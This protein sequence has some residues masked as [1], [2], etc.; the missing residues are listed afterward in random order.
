MQALIRVS[1]MHDVHQDSCDMCVSFVQM[2]PWVLPSLQSSN[3]DHQVG[4]TSQAALRSESAAAIASFFVS[5]LTACARRPHLPWSA[6]TA[7][8]AAHSSQETQGATNGDASADTPHT[9]TVAPLCT[10][11]AHSG[12]VLLF[13]TVTAAMGRFRSQMFVNQVSDSQMQRSSLLV[14]EAVWKF[15]AD[16]TTSVLHTLHWSSAAAGVLLG[17]VISEIEGNS[18]R[19]KHVLHLSWEHVGDCMDPSGGQGQRVQ[20]ERCTLKMSH[21]VPA[22]FKTLIQD[23]WQLSS[24]H[25]AHDPLQGS[26]ASSSKAVALTGKRK[27]SNGIPSSAVT[28][29]KRRSMVEF[30]VEQTH[31]GSALQHATALTADTPAA[32]LSLAF[33]TKQVQSVPCRSQTS[34]PLHLNSE[35][36]TCGASWE[37]QALMS[38]HGIIQ[39]CWH[40]SAQCDAAAVPIVDVGRVFVA[41]QELPD[42]HVEFLM[43]SLLRSIAEY[44]TGLQQQ[45][46]EPV[47][48]PASKCKKTGNERASSGGSTAASPCCRHVAA[49]MAAVGVCAAYCRPGLWKATQGHNKSSV[50]SAARLALSAATHVNKASVREQNPADQAVHALCLA[51][52]TLAAAFEDGALLTAAAAVSQITT[53]RADP[54]LNVAEI[55]QVVANAASCTQ[56]AD[57][58]SEDRE[59]VRRSIESQF[60]IQ[61]EQ[62]AAHCR[63]EQLQG[64][65]TGMVDAAQHALSGT[66]TPAT[67]IMYKAGT[68]LLE[69]QHWEV[70]AEALK[71][72]CARVSLYNL[73]SACDK[74]I[75][76]MLLLGKAC[77]CSADVAH[78]DSFDL[79]EGLPGHIEAIYSVY[80]CACQMLTHSK[81]YSTAA[82]QSAITFLSAFW[83]ACAP[84]AAS[85]PLRS[86]MLGAWQP[87]GRA[88]SLQMVDDALLGHLPSN[89]VSAA[90]FIIS[91][92]T[93]AALH[94]AKRFLTSLSSD[95]S[96]STMG[97]DSLTVGVHSP[98]ACAVLA[99]ALMH[100]HIVPELFAAGQQIAAAIRPRVLRVLTTAASDGTLSETCHLWE[101][102]EVLAV[103]AEACFSFHPLQV[104]PHTVARQHMDALNSGAELLTR[105]CSSW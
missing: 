7:A 71:E 15:V 101:N 38:L 39:T 47:K 70:L 103:L 35:L 22:A 65:C 46:T 68:A 30:A 98:L 52:V 72:V 83:G 37:C 6:L 105:N 44:C 31:P 43:P 29:R 12:F 86:V 76:A 62:V 75:S 53:R 79:S 63:A 95:A 90:A 8:L 104:R 57:P 97:L 41:V 87:V 51:A 88:S 20:G 25:S 42:T 89:L 28:L 27:A 23:L 77:I 34:L 82:M 94:A 40:S 5:M 4:A 14:E 17:A 91:S 93:T 78:S 50:T 80:D 10:E 9:H 49:A 18:D 99:A 26:C 100:E 73:Q 13:S 21:A 92:S 96:M 58:G 11:A 59:D 54:V 102:Q 48:A 61:D 36:Q 74:G 66:C 81:T 55:S 33:G 64:C 24:T 3:A 19:L 84:D 69:S 85:S 60:G 16:T 32:M 67:F 1:L 2:L 56:G 45:L